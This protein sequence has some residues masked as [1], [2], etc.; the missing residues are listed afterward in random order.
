MQVFPKGIQRLGIEKWSDL[1]I[2]FPIRY[3][4]ESNIISLSN[5]NSGM[6]SHS[7]VEILSQKISFKPR[8]M[9]TVTVTD[10]SGS[11]TLRFIYFRQSMVNSLK[12]GNKVRIIGQPRITNKGFEFIHPK[13]RMGW[14]DKSALL[15]K[16]LIPVYSSIKGV[17]QSLIRRW[18]EESINKH[19]PKE[20]LPK[21]ILEELCFFP[22][23]KAVKLIHNPPADAFKSGLL[24]QLI[25]KNGPAWERIK[26]DELIAQQLALFYSREMT[27]KYV[28]PRLADSKKLVSK[29]IKALPF[30]LTNSQKKVWN[31]VFN[32]LKQ[33]SPCNRL[34]QG[35]V[36]SGKTIIAGL[37]IAATVGSNKQA[38]VM[39]PTELLAKQ[40]FTQL[41]NWLKPYGV[42]SLFLKGGQSS[43]NRNHNLLDL[44]EGNV[45]VV[46]GT[47]AII[48]EAV[49]FN[50]LGLSII[51][52]Q[53]RFG[54][55]QR[56]T[57]RKAGGH[58]VVMSAT[59]IPRSLAM[60]FL[61]DLDVSTINELPKI[62]KPVDTRLV[63]SDRRVEICS[64]IQVFIKNGGQV[65]WVC[66]MIDEPKDASRALSAL[67]ATEKWL[68]PIF[69]NNL[70]VVH[71]KQNKEEKNL[72]MQK[73]V[74][75]SA[76]ILLA[77]TVIEVGINVPNAGLIVIE[78][79]E[80]FGLAQ[81]HQLRGRVGRGDRS[82]LC[83][84]M[85]NKQLTDIAKE[86]M[87]I[88][89]STNNGFEVAQKDLELRGPG[90]ILGI[91]QSGEPSLKY[92]NLIDDAHLVEAATRFSDE[93]RL[94][95]SNLS[96]KKKFQILKQNLKD[97]LI[98][99]SH[100]CSTF[101]VG[102]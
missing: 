65:F 6:T 5:L 49:K 32:D 26:F 1:L 30:N 48:Q 42:K 63:S 93:F 91:R 44:K 90:E 77:T 22:L 85:F 55:S 95:S 92:S 40:L 101:F 41:D 58:L 45:D 4:D 7:Q 31:E 69:K 43:K 87:K 66:P 80:R 46:V 73:F 64:R 10:F 9:L 17:S 86:R 76:K 38:A 35:D 75:G 29:V 14:L 25:K 61:A 34:I 54:V 18:V 52:E 37:A 53:H 59:P 28:A 71:G 57:L 68:K 56:V 8:R 97:L 23:D 79:A 88:L 89:Y 84:L 24:N 47:Q 3:E 13:V 83:I 98:R 21:N 16:P 15:N 20:W 81:L 39:A 12:A 67:K 11:A 74:N 33:T 36:G 72:S 50:D 102:S 94:L 78:N 2:Y 96:N 19:C 70:V 62:R 100:D 99:W 27:S 51:D 60:T 82:A